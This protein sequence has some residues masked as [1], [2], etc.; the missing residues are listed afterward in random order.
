M[1][2]LSFS[3]IMKMTQGDHAAEITQ[4]RAENERLR[5][6]IHHMIVRNQFLADNYGLVYDRQDKAKE[7]LK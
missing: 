6:E 3:N 5:E 2:D 1:E 4:L 7:A